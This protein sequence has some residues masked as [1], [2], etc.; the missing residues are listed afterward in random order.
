MRI[1]LDTF[2]CKVN[3]CESAGIARL[4][5]DA[6]H[7]ILI[8]PDDADVILIN[9]CTVTASGD[10]RLFQSLRRFRRQCPHAKIILMGCF[11]QAFPEK[12]LAL[13]IPDIVLGTV[14]REAIC[15]IISRLESGENVPHN[16]VHPLSAKAPFEVLPPERSAGHTRAFLKIQDGCTNFCSYCIIPYARGAGKDMPLSEISAQAQSLAE[17]GAREIVL[18]GINLGRHHDLCKAVQICAKTTGIARVRLGSLEPDRVDDNLCAAL[19][20][21]PEF[22]PSFHLSLQSGS[23][24]TLSAM[25]RRYTAQ[26]YAA[27]CQSIR[28]YFPNAAISTDFMVGF[29][30]ETDDDFRESL[31]FSETI[32]FS[33]MH[34]F[35]YSPRP[36]TL[37]AARTDQ[38]PEAVK[39]ARFSAAKASADR[40]RTACFAQQ[41]G[42]RVPVLFERE[43]SDG[44]HRGLSP[45]GMRVLVPRQSPESLR[46]QMLPVTIS[47]STEDALLGAF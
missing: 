34:V 47:S 20:E 5:R 13:E 44:F 41:I 8:A 1:F 12:A 4:L 32:Q 30:G 19:S 33:A 7:E 15:D 45:N 27:R 18:C 3:S 24:R 11:P 31:A 26:E 9:S 37:A 17:A 28:A 6:G 2:G 38:V 29:P 10:H 23:D 36:G 40:M 14:R 46:Y 16:Q 39:S 22:M 25:H 21:I 43:K 35:R 42:K